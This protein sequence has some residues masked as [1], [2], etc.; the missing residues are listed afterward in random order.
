MEAINAVHFT[1]DDSDSNDVIVHQSDSSD[2]IK[3]NLNLPTRF[4]SPES[5]AKPDFE[6]NPEWE[7]SSSG[8]ES[9]DSKE[10]WF[11]AQK[12]KQ[13]LSDQNVDNNL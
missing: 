12:I 2:V 5:N 10:K 4:L 13:L 3:P 11:Y 1:V 8:A 7:E 9:F 6:D